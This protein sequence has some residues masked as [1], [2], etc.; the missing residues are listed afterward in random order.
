MKCE[1]C[2]GEESQHYYSCN[3]AAS[4]VRFPSVPATHKC[5]KRV[6]LVQAPL[7]AVLVEDLPAREGPDILTYYMVDH[8]VDRSSVVDK[9]FAGPYD[10]VRAQITQWIESHVGPM[11]GRHQPSGERS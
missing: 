3:A 10:E 11:R 1:S 7:V 5:R 2:G 8:Q 4:A 6:V 9:E